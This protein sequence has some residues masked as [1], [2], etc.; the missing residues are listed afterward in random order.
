MDPKAAAATVLTILT[1]SIQAVVG[2]VG[3]P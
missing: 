2:L 3:G 1:P